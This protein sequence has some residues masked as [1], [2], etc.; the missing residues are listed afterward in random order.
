[1][2]FKIPYV[3]DFIKKLCKQQAEVII[4]HDNENVRHNGRGEAQHKEYKR[5]KL[6]GCQT[7]DRSSV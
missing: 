6:G 4:K 3:Y 5:L 1:M 2:A 7:L